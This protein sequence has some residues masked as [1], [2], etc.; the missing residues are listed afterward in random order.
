M[1]RELNPGLFDRTL[2]IMMEI[3]RNSDDLRERGFIM[4]Y[5][6][7]ARAT[8]I[9]SPA[10]VRFLQCLFGNNGFDLETEYV[11]RH[12]YCSSDR[13]CQA[14][15]N[16]I[17]AGKLHYQITGYPGLNDHLGSIFICNKCGEFETVFDSVLFNRRHH[18][19]SVFRIN[20]T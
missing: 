14:C 5:G 20:Y 12:E 19:S 8:G 18:K 11:L 10:R 17:P 16:R 1:K 7:T 2:E 4:K 9:L 15:K 13:V 3:F 6:H